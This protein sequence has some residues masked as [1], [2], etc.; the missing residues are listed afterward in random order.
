MTL[1]GHLSGKSS[2]GHISSLWGVTAEAEIKLRYAYHDSYSHRRSCAKP[3]WQLGKSTNTPRNILIVA[4]H[5]GA[6]RY[7]EGPEARFC[8]IRGLGYHTQK[9]RSPVS[10]LLFPHVPLTMLA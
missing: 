1:D 4:V 8:L 5:W 9:G 7:H 2:S 6:L 3:L 10:R